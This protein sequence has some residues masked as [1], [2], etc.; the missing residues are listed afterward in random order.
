MSNRNSKKW[1]FNRNRN[2]CNQDFS[3]KDKGIILYKAVR[4]H[5]TKSF[6]IELGTNEYE[7]IELPIFNDESNGEVLLILLREIRNIVTE[8][9]T[10]SSKVSETEF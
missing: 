10:C 9:K 6:K 1:Q 7:K 2:F 4:E 8:A 5:E 3:K